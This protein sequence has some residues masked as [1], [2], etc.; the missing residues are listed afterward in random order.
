MKTASFDVRTTASA[1]TGVANRVE[2]SAEF[3]LN[4]DTARGSHR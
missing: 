1:E 3:A 4:V 2:V